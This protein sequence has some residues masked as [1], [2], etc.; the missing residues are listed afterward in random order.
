MLFV[1][2]RRPIS[3]NE[4]KGAGHVHETRS[5][6]SNKEL[7]TVDAADARNALDSFGEV[8]VTG[9]EDMCFWHVVPLHQETPLMLATNGRIGH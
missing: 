6:S 9:V 8:S 4:S 3:T 7:S 5:N 2:L 1:I